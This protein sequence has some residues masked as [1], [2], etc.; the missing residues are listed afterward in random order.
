MIVI[1]VLQILMDCGVAGLWCFVTPWK[2]GDQWLECSPHTHLLLF[3]LDGQ[4]QS[5][6]DSTSIRQYFNR[7]LMLLFAQGTTHPIIICLH[8][9]RL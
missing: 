7:L 1:L 6:F 2:V 3:P 8:F 5:F 9:R 4:A